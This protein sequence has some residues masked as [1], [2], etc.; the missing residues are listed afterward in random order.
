VIKQLTENPSI[1]PALLMP[2]VVVLD[3]TK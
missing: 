1:D 2:D 3:A